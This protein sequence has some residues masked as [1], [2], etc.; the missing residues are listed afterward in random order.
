MLHLPAILLPWFVLAALAF[1]AYRLRLYS[2][3]NIDGQY[4]YAFGSVLLLIATSWQTVKAISDYQSWFVVTAYPVIDFAQFLVGMAGLAL[5]V[6]GLSLY[7]DWQES[8]H[9]EVEIR[10][11]KLS[12]LE[13]LQ[14]DARQ[15]HQLLDLMTL[16]VKEIL[17][18]FPGCAAAVFLVN[19]S[20]RQLILGAS[21][22]LKKEEVAALEY[23]PLDRSLINQGIELGEPTL[24]ARFDFVDREGRTSRSR[25]ESSLI[26]PL[27][28][29]LE[30]MG[31]VVLFSATPKRFGHIELRFLAP[32]AEWLAEKI[33]SAR[34]TREL[35]LAKNDF[36]RIAAEQNALL[37]R[38]GGSLKTLGLV[39]PIAQFCRCLNG[40]FSN[41]AVFICGM[42]QGAFQCFGGSDPNPDFNESFKTALIDAADRHRPLVINQEAVDDHGR[43]RVVR[44]TL[45]V[46]IPGADSRD[47]LLLRKESSPFALST[48]DL[49]IIGLYAQLARLL[50]SQREISRR[51]LASRIGFDKIVGLL[52]SGDRQ[53]RFEEDP[54]QFLR[55]LSDILP[56]SAVAVTY[57]R[58]ADGLLVPAAGF[59]VTIEDTGELTVHPGE[60]PVG[61]A[62]TTA[63][64]KFVAGH[65]LVEASLDAYE[66]TVRSSLQRLFGERGTPVFTA[67]CPFAET[68]R[69][70]GVAAI[71]FFDLPDSEW[72]EWEKLLTL[73]TGLFSFRMTID[74]LQRQ[75]YE[76]SA[77]A[78]HGSGLAPVVN[79]LNNHL[80]VIVGT[81]EIA[82]RRG[83]L[84][85][86]LLLQLRSIMQEAQKAAD[87]ARHSISG[88]VSSPVADSSNS[89]VGPAVNDAVEM[90][91]ADALISGDL[92]MAGGRPREIGCKLGKTA[93]VQFSDDAIRQL[94]ESAL[95]RFAAY[96][97]DDDVITIATYQADN[98]V[99][100]DISRHRKNFPPVDPVAAFGDYHLA[101]QMM[102]TRPS[103][104]FLKP[105]LD[106]GCFYAVDAAAS[107]PAY[108]S[109]KFP[110]RRASGVTGG[111]SRTEVIRVLA[112][113]D[114]SIILDLISAMCQSL[115]YQVV[116]AV[117]GEEGVLKASQGRFDV[118]LTD[119]AMPDISGLDV[120]R[121]VRKLHPDTPI[122]LVTGWEATLDPAQLEAAGI[123]EVLY[124]PF[125]I[126]QLTD[127]VR[128]AASRQPRRS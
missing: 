45:L 85:G 49:E 42:S 46:P 7:A 28:V 90:V 24:G 63:K 35:T 11:S 10:E 60:G 113:D 41:S 94:F 100:L 44:S 112:I 128:A 39:D 120:A 17:T 116:T 93:P 1:T 16:A 111:Q 65:R 4:S 123:S 64:A 33:H 91:L 52:R 67:A 47:I 21:S 105:V 9:E 92:Y 48:D 2:K 73:A 114:Q 76:I 71:Y 106:G 125:R 38:L 96:T 19:R 97:V 27:I 22:G 118:I 40:L 20:R 43:A 31:A 72:P 84:P 57:V 5:V 122:V 119:L 104:V 127:L 88:V 18:P 3:R 86:D 61:E 101:D 115:G 82:A 37:S 124:K 87:L 70:R 8:R 59:R 121:S 36:E 110:V 15:Q 62:A 53:V 68:D 78:L 117:S 98:F 103:D 30:K 95:N 107:A 32:A 83:D 99:Y 54:G 75:H 102:K 51:D 80:S 29:G 13:N 69:V 50:I 74:H 26:L 23:Y 6:V 14:H 81:A 79:D 126:E 25:F 58:S 109:F 66:S 89:H 34:L 55:L 108:L 77:S 56:E 12:I